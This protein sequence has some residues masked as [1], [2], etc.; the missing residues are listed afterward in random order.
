M[1]SS[2]I[3]SNVVLLLSL[4]GCS[5]TDETG[6]SE[7]EHAALISSV[8]GSPSVLR[9]SKNY[10]LDAQSRIFVG[11][12][13]ETRTAS[14]VLLELPYG[15]EIALGDNS[16]FAFNEFSTVDNARIQAALALA[17]GA[18]RLTSSTSIGNGS[19]EIR[20][21]MATIR[22]SEGD[23][24]IGFTPDGTG[25][26]IVMLAGDGLTITNGRFSTEL[27]APGEGLSIVR[28]SGPQAISVWSP[29][30]ISEATAA[31]TLHTP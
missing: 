7:P 22:F 20:T 14:R 4:V 21:P 16:H 24:W 29:R 15:Y 8:M 28:G 19:F 31:T 1:K 17:R 6:P 30:K 12:I 18:L 11:D 26:D 10:I 2:R 23:I 5:A 25:L 13:V 27:S 9:R 3:A